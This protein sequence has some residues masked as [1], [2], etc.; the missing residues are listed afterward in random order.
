MS[1]GIND[2]VRNEVFGEIGIV[3]VTV[4][5]KL[6]DPSAGDLKLIAELGNVW[7]DNTEILSDEWQSAQ[8]SFYR[9]EKIRARTGHPLAGL[10]S[11]CSG[12]YVPRGAKT[13]E[14]IEPNHI[15]KSEKRAE[16]IDAPPITA[17]PQDFPVIDGVP[18]E[19]SLRAEIIRRHASDKS[20]TT[21]LVQQEKLGVPPDVTRVGRNEKREIADQAHTSCPTVS[22]EALPLAEQQKLS[23]VNLLDFA[24]QLAPRAVQSCGI[25]TYQI[26]RPIDIP[27]AVILLFQN[28]KERVIFKPMR[29]LVAELF[30][31]NAQLRAAC[32][33]EID[34]R[35]SRA[36]AA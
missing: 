31:G 11:R 35:L 3:G 15:H 17:L 5:S 36:I 13:A 26:R 23:E 32:R 4:K 8:L 20:R 10:G 19:L 6:E 27:G 16:A 24:P 34:S 30:K 1:T 14:V 25:S 29:L 18:P 2:R 7:R 33:L 22:H 21:M 12:W 28:S 9:V